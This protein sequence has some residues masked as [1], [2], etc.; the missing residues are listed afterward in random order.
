MDYLELEKIYKFAID[1][2]ISVTKHGIVLPT[3]EALEKLRD[4]HKIKEDINQ[5]VQVLSDGY[6]VSKVLKVG[7]E[8]TF[9]ETVTS[10]EDKWELDP[11]EEEYED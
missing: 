9:F 1:N 6:N 4:E 7:D 8:I 3:K 10:I 11:Y 5:Y 2:G